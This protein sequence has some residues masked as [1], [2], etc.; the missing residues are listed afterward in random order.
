MAPSSDGIHLCEQSLCTG[1][2]ACKQKCKA[3]AIFVKNVNG[4]LYPEIDQAKCKSCGMCMT[5]CPVLN[6]QEKKGNC[7]E[8]TTSVIAAWNKK[9]EI[10]MRSSSG[11]IFYTIASTILSNGGVV[12]GAAWQK[13]MS[14]AH[15]YVTRIEDLDPLQ[16]SKYV[17]SNIGDTY[18]KTESFLQQGKT[19]LYCGTPCQIAGLHSFLKKEYPSLYTLDVLCQ[20]VPSP[21]RFQK[22]LTEFEDS[23][24]TKVV[25]CNFRTKIRGWR[26]GLILL[27]HTT[28]GKKY[29][30][31]NHNEY[32]NAFFKEYFMRESCYSC[33]FKEH[34]LGYF[35]DLTVADFWRIGNKEKFEIADYEK[36]VSAIVVNTPKGQELLDKCSNQL[37]MVK[38]TWEEFA[39]NGGLYCS[40]KPQK[41]DEALE[42][43]TD[44]SW[45]DT[46]K[47]YFPLGRKKYFMHLKWLVLG[48][49]NIRKIQKF[50]QLVKKAIGRT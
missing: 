27:L 15:T 21:S 16:R 47:K 33:K 36:G 32:Y 17:Q 28:T 20:G 13:D 42:Y 7:H 46:Q 2:M 41:N 48:E 1:C 18:L 49:R 6:L 26:C 19:V 30:Y 45:A 24:K 11:G 12:F 34:D 43:L 22:Y 3:N 10:R 39:T 29:R 25:D 5:A 37:N 4:F 8:G 50:K 31:L 23:H 38:R 9:P 35:S 40:K 44:H 14:L